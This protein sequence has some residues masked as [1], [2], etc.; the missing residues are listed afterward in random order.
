M[1]KDYRVKVLEYEDKALWSRSADEIDD[2]FAWLKSVGD[3]RTE[4]GKI[5]F[6][7]DDCKENAVAFRL[8]FGI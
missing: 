7:G 4:Y 6:Y 5:V 2:I 8:R 3:Y 1:T